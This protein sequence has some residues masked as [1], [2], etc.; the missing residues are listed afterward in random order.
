MSWLSLNRIQHRWWRITSVIRLEKTV[1][2]MLLTV[3]C[4]LSQCQL[5]YWRSPQNNDIIIMS[6]LLKIY[7]LWPLT[8]ISFWGWPPANTQR[9]HAELRPT[10]HE[11]VNSANHHW[12]SLAVDPFPV[13]PQVKPQPGWPLDWCFVRDPEWENHKNCEVVSVCHFK[14]LSVEAIC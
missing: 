8:E 2:F 12:G 7:C 14:L 6:L 11:E 5:P 9:G 10:T 3:S 1:T 4:W 13:R